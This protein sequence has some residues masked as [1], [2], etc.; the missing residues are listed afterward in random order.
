M[1]NSCSHCEN[2]TPTKLRSLLSFLARTRET[3]AATRT[4][5]SA[6]GEVRN[7][8]QV[9]SQSDFLKTSCTLHPVKFPSEF[10]VASLDVVSYGVHNIS[11]RASD[12]DELWN[13]P[14]CHIRGPRMAS[15]VN[16]AEIREFDKMH[17]LNPLSHGVPSS[18]TLC[19][20]SSS[21]R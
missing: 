8:A 3:S 1:D 2:M 19:F 10:D 18:A 20:P 21:W 13:S 9:F 11:F 6:Q 15:L 5:A 7:T 17:F 12:E 16:L 14:P 4:A